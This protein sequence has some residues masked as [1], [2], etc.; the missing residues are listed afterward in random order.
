MRGRAVNAY[1]ANVWNV[2]ARVSAWLRGLVRMYRR[3]LMVLL[4]ASVTTAV[5]VSAGQSAAPDMVQDPVALT[6]R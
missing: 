3:P 6:L 1:E 5:G 2:S 4:V